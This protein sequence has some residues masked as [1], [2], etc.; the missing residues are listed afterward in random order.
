M[1]R[2]GALDEDQY[3]LLITSRSVLV[4]MRNVFKT[5]VAEKTKTHILCSVTSPLPPP[6]NHDLYD[7]M[8]EKKYF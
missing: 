4:R 1:T 5:K 7:I 3:T 2:M 6:E 8:R